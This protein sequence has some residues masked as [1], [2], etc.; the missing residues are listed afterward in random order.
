MKCFLKKIGTVRSVHDLFKPFEDVPSKSKLLVSV[1]IQEHVLDNSGQDQKYEDG[2]G[3]NVKNDDEVNVVYDDD[4]VRDFR[5]EPISKYIFDK[6]TSVQKGNT[7]RHTCSCQVGKPN[8][9]Y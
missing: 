3:E 9:T 2:D 1:T 8:E 5:M 4:D 7:G 6:R